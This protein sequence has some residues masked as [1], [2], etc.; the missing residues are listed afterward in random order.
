MKQVT[1]DVRALTRSTNV[2]IASLLFIFFYIFARCALPFYTEMGH[3]MSICFLKLNYQVTGHDSGFDHPVSICFIAL[4]AFILPP[5]YQLAAASW[6]VD[7]NSW[8]LCEKVKVSKRC[9]G[10]KNWKHTPTRCQSECS[11]YCFGNQTT[12]HRSWV[13]VWLGLGLG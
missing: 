10:S 12:L 2:K 3:K 13:R 8:K 1:P 7:I 11:P 6:L 9:A 4:S 5:A